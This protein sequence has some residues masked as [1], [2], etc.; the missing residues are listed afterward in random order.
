MAF[1]SSEQNIQEGGL[2]RAVEEQT[3]RVPSMGYLGFAVASM[4]ASAALAFIARKRDLANF[5]G[6]WAPSILIVGVYNKL[7][8]LE[9]EQLSEANQ[10]QYSQRH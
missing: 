6:L 4:A 9:H 7:V 10:S 2:T 1:A 3:G 5:V 8:K